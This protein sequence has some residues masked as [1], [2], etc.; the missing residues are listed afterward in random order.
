MYSK[1][2]ERIKNAIICFLPDRHD[3]SPEDTLDTYSLNNAAAPRTTFAGFAL[4]AKLRLCALGVF[5]V[6][7]LL[8]FNRH[9]D[10]IGVVCAEPRIC[11]RRKMCQYSAFSAFAVPSVKEN[12]SRETDQTKATCR[13][14]IC[15][16]RSNGWHSAMKD[17][18]P[19]LA[20][21]QKD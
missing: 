10:H 2:W 15:Q 3:S 11:W 7:N 13:P 9:V 14:T 18:F 5:L 6:Y 12:N 19:S 21:K 20:K 4:P 8:R 1:G 16:K 17:E